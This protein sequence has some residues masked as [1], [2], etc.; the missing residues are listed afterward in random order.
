MRHRPAKP[1]QKLRRDLLLNAKQAQ[2]RTAL[3]G[4]IEGGIKHIRDH[5]LGQG[6]GIDEHRILPAGFGDQ[7]NRSAVPAGAQGQLLVDLPGDFGRA[8]EDHTV[9]ARIGHQRRTDLTVALQTMQPFP[10]DAR[11]MQQ[12][13][14]ESGNAGR[15]LRRLGEHGIAGGQSTRRPARQKSPAENSTG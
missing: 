10:R 8:G 3:A 4:G 11:L 13:H 14:G 15:L 5:L 12:R 2:G 1:R 7:R 6:G 9:A